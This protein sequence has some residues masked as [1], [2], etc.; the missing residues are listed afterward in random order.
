MVTISKK[1][2]RLKH[3]RLTKLTFSEAG[4]PFGY[5]VAR[6]F[7]FGSGVGRLGALRSLLG[8]GSTRQRLAAVRAT[9]RRRSVAGLGVLFG[10]ISVRATL[11]RHHSTINIIVVVVVV[12]VIIYSTLFAVPLNNSHIKT[13]KNKQIIVTPVG[14]IYPTND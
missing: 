10:Q 11:R 13:T 1:W 8:V 7:R 9:Q 14:H 3:R 2:G 12:V 6:A 4:R 5:Q